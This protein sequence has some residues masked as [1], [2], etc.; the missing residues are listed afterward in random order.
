M[1]LDS[2]RYR[3]MPEANARLAALQNGEAQLI[4]SVPSELSARVAQRKDLAFDAEDFPVL[5]SYFVRATR[6]RG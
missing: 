2:V 5:G 1:Y 4:S 6:R 3:F